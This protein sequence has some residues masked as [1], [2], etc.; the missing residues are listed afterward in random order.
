MVKKSNED[1]EFFRAEKVLSKREFEELGEVKKSL[2]KR[3]FRKQLKDLKE[4]QK[5]LRREAKFRASRTGKVYK[6]ISKGFGLL[7]KGL[8]R[9]LQERGQQPKILQERE[10]Q[11]QIIS[12]SKGRVKFGRGRPK[13]TVKFRDPRTGQPIGVF[14]YRKILSARLR[15]ERIKAQ[16]GA[17]LDP[18]QRVTLQRLNQQRRFEESNIENK[19]IPD[20]LGNIFLDGIM[21]EIN[22]ASNIVK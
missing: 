18:R 14:E 5:F 17:R 1:K 22:Q 7:Q 20:T 9:S 2:A 19:P 11:L 10:Q 16:A 3:K 21:D 15:A 4:E 8:T 6:G 12:Q 13:G